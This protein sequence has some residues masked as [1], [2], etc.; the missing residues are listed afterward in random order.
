M[1]N[2]I[3]FRLPGEMDPLFR[4]KA[5]ERKLKPTEYAQDLALQSLKE[6]GEIPMLRESIL[7]LSVQLQELR[8]DVGLCA[9]LV[10]IGTRCMTEAE[11]KA[12]VKEN[13]LN[14]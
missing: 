10:L 12:W 1:G 2:P 9:Q 11:A 6:G 14:R 7:E 4:A 13:L 3:T 8:K 5:E